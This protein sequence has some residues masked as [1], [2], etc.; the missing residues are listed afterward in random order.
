MTAHHFADSSISVPFSSINVKPNHDDV[1]KFCLGNPESVILELG[2]QEI[3]FLKPGGARIRNPHGLNA[4]S[5]NPES[6]SR[7]NI[8]YS[9][10]SRTYV[11][12]FWKTSM[13][14]TQTNRERE[15]PCARMRAAPVFILV[16]FVTEENTSLGM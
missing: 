6:R 3:G 5:K 16:T 8:A 12:S 1:T 9:F 4:K 13:I 11:F 10:L 15:L 7:A 2:F 14:H